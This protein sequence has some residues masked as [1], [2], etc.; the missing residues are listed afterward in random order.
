MAIWKD[1]SAETAKLE[2][3][4]QLLREKT[5]PKG[6]KEDVVLPAFTWKQT[7]V[8]INTALEMYKNSAF[9]RI[10]DKSEMFE[11]WLA[12]L[13][14]DSYASAISGAFTMSVKV[15]VSYRHVGF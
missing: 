13:P 5:R 10:C 7:V 8:E 12:L 3:T 15:R 6:V 1:A 11:Q 9:V 14:N 2:A 4:V